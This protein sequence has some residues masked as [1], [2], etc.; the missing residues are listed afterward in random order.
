MA[1]KTNTGNTRDGNRC[2]GAKMLGA[3]V[4]GAAVKAACMADSRRVFL[5]YP[6]QDFEGQKIAGPW[7]Q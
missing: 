6:R 2:G 7:K 1:A 3:A 4:V 5:R